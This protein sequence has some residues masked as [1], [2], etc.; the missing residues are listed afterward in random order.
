[1]DVKNLEQL[2][3]VVAAIRKVADVYD[4]KRVGA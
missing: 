2:Q 4:V 1:V 3:L